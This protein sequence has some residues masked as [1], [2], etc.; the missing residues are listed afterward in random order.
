MSWVLEKVKRLDL[1]RDGEAILKVQSSLRKLRV[2]GCLRTQG[3]KNTQGSMVESS[4]SLNAE[5]QKLL[6]L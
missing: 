1:L 3:S 4:E 2:G 5:R 6:L